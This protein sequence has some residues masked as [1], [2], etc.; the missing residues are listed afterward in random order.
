MRASFRKALYNH[1]GSCIAQRPKLPES[2]RCLRLLVLAISAKRFKLRAKFS[3]GDRE[4]QREPALA[5]AGV[6][7]RGCCSMHDD[8]VFCDGDYT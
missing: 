2:S 7:L 6:D 3:V 4:T 1:T 8:L 5:H